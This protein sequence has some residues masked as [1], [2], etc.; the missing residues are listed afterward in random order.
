MK[1]I[2]VKNTHCQHLIY[3]ASSALSFTL[4]GVT[5]IYLNTQP[6]EATQLAPD[7]SGFLIGGIC[8]AGAA[9]LVRHPSVQS[10]SHIPELEVDKQRRDK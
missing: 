3:K 7:N 4:Y 6:P 9:L 1:A 2:Y 5:E 8:L 10:K